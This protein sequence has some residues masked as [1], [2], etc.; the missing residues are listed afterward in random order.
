VRSV[1]SLFNIIVERSL[2]ELLTDANIFLYHLLLCK[3]LIRL[4]LMSIVDTK[5]M[6]Q[7]KRLYILYTHIDSVVAAIVIINQISAKQ[8]LKTRFLLLALITCILRFVTVKTAL[9]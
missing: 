9:L 7:L 6:L 3:Q 2:L 4:L 5:A 8:I 1:R